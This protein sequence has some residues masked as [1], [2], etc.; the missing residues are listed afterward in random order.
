MVRR[1]LSLFA[2]QITTVSVNIL[3]KCQARLRIVGYNLQHLIQHEV[4]IA[5]FV[6]H[7]VNVDSGGWSFTKLYTMRDALPEIPS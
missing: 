6:T 4:L 2:R 1:S 7:N 3:T 5:V